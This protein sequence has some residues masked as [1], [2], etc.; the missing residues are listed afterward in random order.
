MAFVLLG[1]AY[2]DTN[3][4]DAVKCLRK[5]ISKSDDHLLALQGLVMCAKDDEL[6]DIYHE[7]LELQP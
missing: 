2:Q 3:K 1:A 6:P 4:E 5:A 7:L